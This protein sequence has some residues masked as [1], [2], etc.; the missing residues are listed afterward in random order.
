M[1]AWMDFLKTLCALAGAAAILAT[2]L[3]AVLFH[4]G[5]RDFQD[6]EGK[7]G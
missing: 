2:G 4:L 1:Q 5:V 6:Y 7:N 3:L